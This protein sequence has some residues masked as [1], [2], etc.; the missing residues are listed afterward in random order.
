[1]SGTQIKSICFDRPIVAMEAYENLLAVVFHEGVPIYE[2]Q[3]LSMKL[4]CVSQWEVLSVSQCHVPLTIP[5]PGEK[6]FVLRW[7]G[8]SMEGMLFSKDSCGVI[9]AYSL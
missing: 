8:F 9:R 2:A 1:M 4:F 6:G 5:Q 7:F 3:L